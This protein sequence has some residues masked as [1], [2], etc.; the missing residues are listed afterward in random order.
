MVE[1]KFTLQEWW[2]SSDDGKKYRI[3]ASISRPREVSILVPE[4]WSKFG[5]KEQKQIQVIMNYYLQVRFNEALS[6]FIKTGEKSPVRS[7]ALNG[8]LSALSKNSLS[9]V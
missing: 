6:T 2:L 7:D 5:E 8:V 1:Q 4:E 3:D 9:Q